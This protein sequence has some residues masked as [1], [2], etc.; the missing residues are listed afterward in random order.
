MRIL[1]ALA[2]AS[3]ALAVA[4]SHAATS[5]IDG[6]GAP[7][8]YHPLV[9]GDFDDGDG[10]SGAP[11]QGWSPVRMVGLEAASGVL[12]NINSAGLGSNNEG[13]SYV[14]LSTGS[15]NALPGVA[16][17][18]VG[19]LPGQYDIVQFDL[20]FDVL[21]PE[22]P[23]NPGSGLIDSRLKGRHFLQGGS[24]HGVDF[25]NN[26]YLQNL[27]DTNDTG[28]HTYTIVRDFNDGAWEAL[29]NVVRIDMID[30]VGAADSAS[31]LGTK[32]SLD[33]I[34][35]G[36]TTATE[37][38]PA[39]PVSLT[40]IIKN[41]DL[42]Q[43]SNLVT[44]GINDGAA[45][46]NGGNGHY[47]P[48]RG[49]SVDVDHWTPYNNNPNSIVEAVNGTDGTGLNLL[50]VAG[51][52]QGSWYL[53]THWSTGAEQF[54]LNSAGGY[55]NGLIQ[56]DVLNGVTIDTSATYELA[57]DINFNTNRPSNP[58]SNFKVALT[59][60]T[61]STD[62]NTA[63]AGSLFDGQLSGITPGTQTLSISGAVL[64]TAQDSGQ[65]VNLIVQSQANTS[66]VNFPGTPVPDNHV[67]PAVFTQVQ[68]DNLALV[69]TFTIQTG[70]VNKDGLVT[71]ADVNLA[72]LYL[73]G[74]GG[75][76]AFK[77][78]TDLAN[79]PSAPFASDILASLNLT[80]FDLVADSFFDA[81]DVAAIAAL[82]VAVP[83][84]FDS[85]GDVD[86][87][88]FL[89]WQRNTSVGNLA[90]WQA[91]YGV[92]LSAVTTAVPEPT[93]LVLV[94]LVLSAATVCGRR[95]G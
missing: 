54:S 91:N 66:I 11:L 5:F 4:S 14:R 51:T 72:Q 13:D 30:G 79:A 89:V 25:F 53:D 81:A 75:E 88:D 32:F 40:N 19:E 87:R 92:G 62:P 16:D 80:D 68:V 82:V 22:D 71:Q 39:I 78:Q 26:A 9:I 44:S 76:T 3:I 67:D 12:T 70:D 69:K 93:S 90:D 33:N 24:T 48:F 74:N 43:V 23:N 37:A 59:V 36:R 20:R 15:G 42:S 6:V 47:G 38:F 63:V 77:R 64:K 41:G 31:T 65:P 83:G 86:G 50:N 27:K 18:K 60:G 46:I 7:T 95:R 2:C 52:T 28:F 21:P 45:D 29:E 56:T 85:D 61:N 35:L 10:S 94:G 73:D 34:I 1:H 8:V 58:N 55:L 17:F 57:F 84:D 49:S